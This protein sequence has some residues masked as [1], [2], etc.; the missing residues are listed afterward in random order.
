MTD[1]LRKLFHTTLQAIASFLDKAGV[2]PNHLT[3][4]GLAGHLLPAWLI[5]EGHFIFGAISL[6]FFGLFDALDGS[7]ARYQNKVTAF[8]AYL[9]SV[10][11]RMAEGI[12]FLGLLFNFYQRGS[13][14]GCL[15]VFMAAF[16]SILVSYSRARAE[17]VNIVPKIG[18]LTRVERYLLL[19]VALLLDKIEA[20][21][22]LIAIFSLVT[23]GQR[24]WYVYCRLPS[25]EES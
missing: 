21:L 19:I 8:G 10:C 25:K 18:V 4:L 13:Q 14:I 24:V 7:L 3:I 16:G 20:G 1:F 11:D 5:V 9:D 12:I 22:M 15:L 2:H 23:V 6:L 17:A